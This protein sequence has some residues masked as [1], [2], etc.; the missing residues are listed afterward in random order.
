[1]EFDITAIKY[2]SA[3][4]HTVTVCMSLALSYPLFDAINSK[5]PVNVGV[6]N[7]G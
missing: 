7:V 2:E 5:L 4:R 1:M 3:F 6:N